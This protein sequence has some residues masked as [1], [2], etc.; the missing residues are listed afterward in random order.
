MKNWKTTTSGIIAALGQI[1]P[2]FGI[3]AE[4][5]QAASVL[6]LFLVGL[7][8]KDAGVSGTQF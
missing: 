4:I 8:S 5:G 6:G 3:P 1:L 2:I 7:F